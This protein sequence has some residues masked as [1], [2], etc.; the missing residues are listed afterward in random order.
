ML[1]AIHSSRPSSK[2]LTIKISNMENTNQP[3]IKC[4]AI[5]HHWL[6]KISSRNV[7]Q[8]IYCLIFL[9]PIFSVSQKALYPIMLI[10]GICLGLKKR[11]SGRT[12]SK[13]SLANTSAYLWLVPSII[14]L[15][16]ATK[17]AINDLSTGLITTQ[18]ELFSSISRSL[19]YIIIPIVLGKI[20]LSSEINIKSLAR[21]I[22]IGM[23][24]KITICSILTESITGL[25]LR[26]GFI[27]EFPTLRPDVSN[28][29][30]TFCIAISSLLWIIY[31]SDK[32]VASKRIFL[33]FASLNLLTVLAW[34][35]IFDNL[36]CGLASLAIVGIIIIELTRDVK[37]K[38]KIIFWIAT[39]SAVLC[40]VFPNFISRFRLQHIFT[41]ND[42]LE[43]LFQGFR[44]LQSIQFQNEYIVSGPP[45]FQRPICFGKGEAIFS[46][47][48]CHNYWHNL[49]W[50]GM[51]NFG[52]TGMLIACGIA[53][54]IL[55][56]AIKSCRQEQWGSLFGSLCCTYLI[57]SRPIVEA[58]AGEVI[59]VILMIWFC[60][61]ELASQAY[62]A[63]TRRYR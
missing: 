4:E 15:A 41:R 44:R 32:K 35:V 25:P 48:S 40:S 6:P 3:G 29:I 9:I 52:F 20:A 61:H 45:S 54:F 22:I 17:N 43:F 14:F 19:L 12:I 23:Q 51:R 7:N 58:G 53:L 31:F 33:V 26:K 2:L 8:L 49:I 5:G 46:Q 13:T 11:F 57:F 47:P 60:C 30:G 27:L 21:T 55:I 18:N 56:I 63:S 34:S 42:R 16:L 28:W 59:P 38:L 36:S 50:D 39:A 1:V 62:N 24:T 37:H 10:I